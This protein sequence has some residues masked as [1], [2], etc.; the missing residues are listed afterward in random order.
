[1]STLPKLSELDPSSPEWMETYTRLKDLDEKILEERGRRE[2][3]PHAGDI[4]SYEE[5]RRFPGLPVKFT[6]DGGRTW[7]YATP[8]AI[9]GR[10]NLELMPNIRVHGSIPFDRRAFEN[11]LVVRLAGPA[12]LVEIE[13]SYAR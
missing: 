1:M 11:G 4:D 10:Y 12:E 6:R 9:G 2:P 13:F 5:L 7:Q 8:L 3:R